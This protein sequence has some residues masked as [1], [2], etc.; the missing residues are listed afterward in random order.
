[1]QSHFSS[2]ISHREVVS[3][4][5]SANKHSL[6]GF[7]ILADAKNWTFIWSLPRSCLL[8]QFQD[9]FQDFLLHNPAVHFCFN[10]FISSNVGI[11]I[12][13]YCLILFL[14][15]QSLVTNFNRSL[16]PE[17]LSIFSFFLRKTTFL[18][19]G[20]WPTLFKH[21]MCLA[22]ILHEYSIFLNVGSSIFCLQDPSRKE[23]QLPFA[24]TLLFFAIKSIYSTLVLAYFFGSRCWW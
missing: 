24:N 14:L 18:D 19:R 16:H 12:F 4:P 17:M 15:I 6:K 1:M 23:C 10:S 13:I 21:N 22:S 5:S 8:L 20:L 11:A 7:V 2:R 3:F 9:P